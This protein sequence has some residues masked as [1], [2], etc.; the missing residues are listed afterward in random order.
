MGENWFNKTLFRLMVV[1]SSVIE[2]RI[3]IYQ[4][5]I[6]VKLVSLKTIQE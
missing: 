6:I 5:E 1:K 3:L 2:D 4:Q